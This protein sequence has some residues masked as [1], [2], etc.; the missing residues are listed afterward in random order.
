MGMRQGE[1]DRRQTHRH[2]ASQ[3]QTR[4]Q[5]RQ[6]DTET[7]STSTSDADRW[8]PKREIEREREREREQ[9]GS[10]RERENER[11]SSSSRQR[12]R[13]R[14]RDR[15]NA[16]TLVT[17][18]PLAPSNSSSVN[19][20]WNRSASTSLTSA[21]LRSTWFPCTSQHMSDL[22]VAHLQ[23][24]SAPDSAMSQLEAIAMS[25]PGFRHHT[26]CS[27][28]LR[29]AVPGPRRRNQRETS[30]SAGTDC[31]RRARESL[32]IARSGARPMQ[33]PDIA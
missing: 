14:D 6:T 18:G 26:V 28:T 33:V 8:D 15:E 12:D 30:M 21:I 9:E 24:M 19:P 20:F 11:S 22:G 29:I 23:R 7:P 25:V 10:E 1:T 32:L 31:T 27:R 13:D 2:P 16:R 3:E 5:E 17:I 4:Q